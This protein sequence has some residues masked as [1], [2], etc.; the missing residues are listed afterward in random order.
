MLVEEAILRPHVPG[1][2]TVAELFTHVLAGLCLALVASWRY[3]WVTPPLVVACMVGAAIPDLNRIMSFSRAETITAITGLPWSWA[4]THR[5]GGALRIALM[6]TLLVRKTWQTRVRPVLCRHC[7]ARRD[8][9]LPLAADGPNE[10][11]T[12]AA[13]P[14]VVPLVGSRESPGTSNLMLWPFLDLSLDYP[15][16]YRSTDRWTAAVAL[17][18]TG[19]VI[20]VDRYGVGG[21][22]RH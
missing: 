22:S 5:A 19:V 2:F 8:R 13:V 12:P 3:E 10:Q 9:L 6:F 11:H 20:T 18:V 21:Q 17:V 4:I 1:V 14:V 16:F 7:L 15:G